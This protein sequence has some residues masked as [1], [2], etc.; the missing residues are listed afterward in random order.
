MY[1]FCVVLLAMALGQVFGAP[2][3][4]TISSRV[5]E[6]LKTEGTVDIILNM[7]QKTSSVLQ[8]IKQQS[9]ATQTARVSSVASSLHALAATSQKSVLAYLATQDNEVRSLW[10]S[11]QISVKAASV[12][13][14]QSLASMPEIESIIADKV[15]LAP[16]PTPTPVTTQPNA[17]QW[18][19]E[20]VEAPAAWAQGFTGNDVVVGI[21]DTGVRYTH[22]LLYPNYRQERGW[23]DASSGSQTPVDDWSG[24]GSHVMGSILGKDGVGV[25]PDAKWIACRTSMTFSA[26]SEYQRCGQFVSLLNEIQNLLFLRNHFF[27]AALSNFTR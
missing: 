8:S 5:L 18:G 15:Q 11:N 23:L 1:K 21:L 13:L 19:V 3:S 12:S 2:Y 9:F 17:L 27:L 7:H 14:I 6:E 16:L 4:A 25:A 24:H 10:I 26:L 20:M 22:K